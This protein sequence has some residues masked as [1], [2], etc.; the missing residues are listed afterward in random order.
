MAPQQIKMRLAIETEMNKVFGRDEI[1][2]SVQAGS[3]LGE[4]AG[5]HGRHVGTWSTPWLLDPPTLCTSTCG[6]GWK[7]CWGICRVTVSN[8]VS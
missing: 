7:L 4:I 2:I 1:D 3:T 8:V 5:L 6:S